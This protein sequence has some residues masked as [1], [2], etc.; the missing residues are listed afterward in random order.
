MNGLN[1]VSRRSAGGGWVRIGSARRSGFTLIEVLIVIAIILALGAIVGVAVFQRRDTADI[2]MTKIQL[3]QIGNALDLFY[4]DFRR[5]PNDDEG[6]A[7]LWDKERLDP[8]AD[9]SKW[10]QY[11]KDPLPRDVW[12]NEWG[13]RGEE[14]EHGDK[15]DLWSNGPDGEEGT[16]DDITEWN[17]SSD[18]EFGDDLG[19][20]LPAPPSSDGP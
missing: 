20:D 12:N 18:D 14:P 5:Y 11:M 4:L 2:D 16:D 9:E 1:G 7:V 6:L 3:K 19:S 10:Q 8:D 17:Q 15:Y 13:Y